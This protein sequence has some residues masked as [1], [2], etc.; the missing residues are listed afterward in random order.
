MPGPYPALPRYYGLMS[1]TILIAES[2]PAARAALRL[3]IEQ[4]PGWQPAGEAADVTSLLRQV[5]GRIMDVVLLDWYLPGLPPVQTI[6]LLRR[7]QP[8]LFVA[9]L[10]PRS[11][12]R[13]PALAAGAD[14]FIWKGDSLR[15]LLS[16]IRPSEPLAGDQMAGGGSQNE[17]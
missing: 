14:E 13:L 17:A 6:R 11:E 3:L 10:S 5:A 12:D 2:Q 1:R 15:R 16:I 8:G 4:Q 7:E 9:V